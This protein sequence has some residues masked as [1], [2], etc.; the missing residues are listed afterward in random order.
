MK[1]YIAL[2]ALALLVP[3]LATAHISVRPRESKPCAEES[4]TVRVPTEGTVATTHVLL[5]VPP[6]ATVL[7]VLLAAGATFETSTEGGRITTI[8]W[9]EEIAPKQAAEFMFSARNPSA[10]DIVWKAHQHFADGTAADWVGPAGDRR[11]AAVTNLTAASTGA[12]GQ[13]N[14]DRRTI[15]AAHV[16]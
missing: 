6:D 13:A 9:K 14:D 8:T 7:E 11:P 2:T 12:G 16:R 10:G 15:A 5:E 3:S 1:R 4:C